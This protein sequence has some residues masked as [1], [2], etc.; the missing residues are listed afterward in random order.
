MAV[1]L[2]LTCAGRRST[3]RQRLA[4]VQTIKVGAIDQPKPSA[5]LIVE[6]RNLVIKSRGQ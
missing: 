2:E 1:D 5:S 6:I 4:S 3:P